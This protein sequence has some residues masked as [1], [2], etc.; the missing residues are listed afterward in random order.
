MH[1]SI[2]GVQKIRKDLKAKRKLL[3][4]NFSKNPSDTHLA[5][6]IKLLDDQISDL[7]RLLSIHFS[8][9]FRKAS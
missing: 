7:D 8:S 2:V 1:Q 3:F 4:A 6:E 5:L 9:H